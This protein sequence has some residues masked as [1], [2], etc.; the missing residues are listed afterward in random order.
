MD[1][2]I[3]VDHHAAPNDRVSMSV[4]LQQH[5]DFALDND[6]AGLFEVVMNKWGNIVSRQT[7][8]NSSSESSFLKMS[9]P[10]DNAVFA[11]FI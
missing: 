10:D 9:T 1:T 11:N 7:R 3:H 2:I 4:V 8:A 6:N 5:D